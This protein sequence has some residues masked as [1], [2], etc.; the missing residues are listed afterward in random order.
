MVIN[1]PTNSFV[2]FLSVQTLCAEN[3]NLDSKNRIRILNMILEF[4]NM[5]WADRNL[6]HKSDS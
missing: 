1:S 4:K 2:L 5:I 3:E 6:E